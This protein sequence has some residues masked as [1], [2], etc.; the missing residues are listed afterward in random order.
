MG[1]GVGERERIIAL[2]SY[3]LP[4]HSSLYSVISIASP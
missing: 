3:L 1:Y 4:L 2:T